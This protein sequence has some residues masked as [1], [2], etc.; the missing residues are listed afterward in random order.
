[1]GLEDIIEFMVG[2]GPGDTSE[3]TAMQPTLIEDD[4]ATFLQLKF[5][6]RLNAA[7]FRVDVEG[8]V[9]GNRWISVRELF[10]DLTPADAIENGIRSITLRSLAPVMTFPYRFFRLRIT[11]EI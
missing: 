8:S 1:M 3:A 6:E 5:R 2:T 4:N 10:Q 9:D 11:S 7:W